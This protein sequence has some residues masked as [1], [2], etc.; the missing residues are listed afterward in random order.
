M[1]VSSKSTPMCDSCTYY[2]ILV[3]SLLYFT[4]YAATITILY[5]PAW[6]VYRCHLNHGEVK[7]WYRTGTMPTRE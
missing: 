7:M 5:S 3:V 4:I 6:L 2:Y 1:L